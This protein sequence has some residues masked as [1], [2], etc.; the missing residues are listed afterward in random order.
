MDPL[1]V[2]LEKKNIDANN[3]VELPNDECRKLRHSIYEALRE[4]TGTKVTDADEKKIRSL[5]RSDLYG[6]ESTR[7]P[8]YNLPAKRKSVH[9]ADHVVV[10]FQRRRTNKKP[11]YTL[12][13]I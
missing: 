3:G 2:I 8:E 7:G 6:C 4:F 13:S 5:V 1:E 9:V 12:G 11:K 10:A